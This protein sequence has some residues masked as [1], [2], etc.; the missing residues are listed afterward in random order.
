MKK[1]N[2]RIEVVVPDP[3]PNGLGPQARLLVDGKDYLDDVFEGV[4]CDPDELIGPFSPL[5]ADD[6]PRDVALMRCGCGVTD[7]NLLV[8]NVGR[9]GGEIVWDDFRTGPGM[10]PVALTPIGLHTLRFSADEYLAELDRAHVERE[11]EPAWRTAGRLVRESLLDSQ[12]KLEALG[13]SLRTTWHFARKLGPR[14]IKNLRRPK[15]ALGVEL[16]EMRDDQKRQVVMAFSTDSAD[17]PS[18]AADIADTILGKPSDAWPIAY[19]GEWL[20]N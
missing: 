2:L 20:S 14:W 13:Y 9:D 6:V 3:D 4:G 15:H 1:S 16:W 18:R 17:P 11:W 8:V 19:L 12:N 10:D 7:C 5:R